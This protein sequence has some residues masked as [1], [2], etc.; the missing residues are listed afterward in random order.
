ME[1][2]D[3]RGFSADYL[4]EYNEVDIALDTFPYTGGLTTVEALLMGVPVISMYGD[5]HG[6][7]FGLGFLS[8]IGMAELATDN[9]DTYIS[10]AAGIAADKELL[11]VLHGKLRSMVQESPLMDGA[12][13]CR[14]VERM[15]RKLL[16]VDDVW[17]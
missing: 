10:V 6:T 14:D 9:K 7:R 13:Y 16:Y 4:Q 8:N 2:I 15:Y 3:F 11:K 5:R 12:G 17:L 1:R